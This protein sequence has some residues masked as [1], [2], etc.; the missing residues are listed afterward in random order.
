MAK[1]KDYNINQRINIKSW[2]RGVYSL[3][4]IASIDYSYD[5]WSY[6]LTKNPFEYGRYC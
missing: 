5:M 3:A 6:P 4:H 1:Y 2:L